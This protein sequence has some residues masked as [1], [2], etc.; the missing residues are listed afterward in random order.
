MFNNPLRLF[1]NACHALR[2]I[3]SENSKATRLAASVRVA[4]TLRQRIFE[5]ALLPGAPLREVQL[6]EELEVSRNTLREAL[7]LLESEDLLD[8]RLHRGVTVKQLSAD[9][10]RDIFV[11]RR[12][13]ELRAVDEMYVTPQ[14]IAALQQ[15]MAMIDDAVKRNAWR[16]V[17]TASLQF[18]RLLVGT[19][20][21]SRLDRFFTTIVAQIRLAF[22]AVADERDF[23]LSFVRRDREIC[24]FISAG[25][26]ASA[27]AALSAYLASSELLL[28]KIIEINQASDPSTPDLQTNYNEGGS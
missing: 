7:R 9:E 21:S 13:L 22:A 23:Q 11:A 10:V 26:R 15:A 25:S 8:L 27:A 16:E 24:D 1:N 28:T 4:D 17:G 3:D 12:A 2:M 20:N 6:A 5:G 18:H 19:L 14:T